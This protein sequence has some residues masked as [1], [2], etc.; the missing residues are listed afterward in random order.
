MIRVGPAPFVIPLPRSVLTTSL[1]GAK[2]VRFSDNGRTI[3]GNATA[4]LLRMTFLPAVAVPGTL[5]RVNFAKT[6]VTGNPFYVFDGTRD[7]V[8]MSGP[9][10]SF[11]IEAY[12]GALFSIA[13]DA[14]L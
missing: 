10:E 6:D 11:I 3:Y 7:F 12:S 14:N 5:V 13:K 1:S 2:I 9:G 4:G 8:V